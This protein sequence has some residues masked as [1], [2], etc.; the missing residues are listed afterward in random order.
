MSTM[1]TT[2]TQ[3]VVYDLKRYAGWL[4]TSTTALHTLVLRI[5]ETVCAGGGCSF[6]REMVD[7][8]TTVWHMHASV[9]QLQPIL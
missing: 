8:T 1:P 4:Q 2:I 7:D 9:C 5:R 6:T 3:V